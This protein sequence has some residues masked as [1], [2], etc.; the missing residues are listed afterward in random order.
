MKMNLLSVRMINI[1]DVLKIKLMKK[2]FFTVA[3]IL[4]TGY[5]S[6]SQTY[7]TQVRPADSKFWGY[8]NEKGELIIPAQF[9][10][11]YKFSPEG[12]AVIYDTDEN[13]YYFINT[14]GEKLQTEISKF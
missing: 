1:F 3:F 10:K 13:Q 14:K 6:F 9:K 4:L 12:L 2:H 5:I 11:C 7:I 8:A